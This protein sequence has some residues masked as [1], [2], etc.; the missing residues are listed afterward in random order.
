MWKKKD[1]VT[2]VKEVVERN[3][4]LKVEEL[5]NPT[6]KPF[7]KN[8]TEMGNFIKSNLEMPI[9]IIGDYDCDGVT[10]SALLY[11]VLVALGAKKVNVRLPKRFSEGY[12]LNMS[13]IDEIENG[14][15]L[16]VDNGIVATEQ[17]KKAI[18]KGLLVGIIDHHIGDPENLPNAHCIV[19]PNALPGEFN[20]YCA[21]GLAYRLAEEL[22]VETPDMLALAA[23]GT[24]ADVMELK[25]DN[26]RLVIEG[27]RTINEGKAGEGIYALLNEFNLDLVNEDTIGFTIG[28]AI[29]ASGRMFDNGAITPFMLLS[30]KSKDLE[31]LAKDLKETNESRKRETVKAMELANLIIAEDCLYGDTPLVIY[32]DKEQQ[33]HEGIVGIVAGRLAEM[34]KVPVFVFTEGEDGN[35][36]GSAR[37]FGTFNVKNLMDECQELLIKYGGHAGAGGLSCKREDI[38]ALKAKMKSLMEGYSE[39]EKENDL[40][41]LEI[42]AS[43]IPSI[44]EELEKYAPYG[45]GNRRPIFKVNHYSLFPKNGVC[46]KTIGTNGIKLFGGDSEAIAFGNERFQEL[47]EP[48]ILTIYGSLSV[49]RWKGYVTNQLEFVD[50]EDGSFKKKESGLSELL[51]SRMGS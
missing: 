31:G 48:K 39:P 22:K 5:I 14:L 26:R 3:T 21:A 17:V 40:F 11:K 4:G 1:S 24:V 10:S 51:K 49:N 23:I 38:E 19:D 6:V 34:H 8:L 47:G 29:N 32:G 15:I 41:D 2:T 42:E 12:G 30:E 18:D 36:K 43:E 9:T 35:L 37:T 50:L 33:F 13:I 7:I 25:H 44:I 28:P 16:T 27:L 46:F 20:G 45:E